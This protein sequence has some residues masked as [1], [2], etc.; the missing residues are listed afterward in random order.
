M[1]SVNRV[2]QN[3]ETCYRPRMRPFEKSCTG[4]FRQRHGVKARRDKDLTASDPPRAHWGRR[5]PNL[6]RSYTTAA[7]SVRKLGGVRLI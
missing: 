1:E 6:H 7:A 4:S 5:T 3:P 2:Y